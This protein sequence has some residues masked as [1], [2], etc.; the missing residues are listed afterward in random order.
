MSR[1]YRLLVTCDE[2]GSGDCHGVLQFRVEQRAHLDGLEA[3]LTTMGWH[4]GVR[5][6]GPDGAVVD[7]CPDCWPALE[8]RLNRWGKPVEAEAT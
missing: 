4:T 1:S 6:D 2:N 7:V 8:R 3:K 5:L